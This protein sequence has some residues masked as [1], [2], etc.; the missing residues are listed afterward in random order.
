MKQSYRFLLSLSLTALLIYTF[1]LSS[2]PSTSALGELECQ[3]DGDICCTFD[4]VT[5]K[6]VECGRDLSCESTP[7]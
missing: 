2:T 5:G 7:Q 1:L 6:I 4:S 3:C